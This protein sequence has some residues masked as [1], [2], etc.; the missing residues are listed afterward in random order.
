MSRF[1]ERNYLYRRPDL[2]DALAAADRS[3][4]EQVSRLAAA[5]AVSHTASLCDFGCGTGRDLGQLDG[6]S[7]RVGVDIQEGMISYG[8]RLRPDLDLK[9]GDLR[10]IRLE[11]KFDVLVCLGNS[12]AYLHHDHEQLNAWETFT[13]HARSETLLIIQTLLEPV[14][15][16][17]VR[18][19][20]VDTAV[21]EADT[22]WEI[23]WENDRRIS[24][25]RRTWHIDE[26]QNDVIER[27]VTTPEEL[28]VF[29]VQHGWTVPELALPAGYF[30]AVLHRT[31]PPDPVKLM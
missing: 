3:K 26:P 20:R 18:T 7:R 27:R 4:V 23:S 25:M 9:V 31:G 12:Y 6:F 16:T 19:G 28:T 24:T 10:T 2:Y 15:P 13:A 8:R 11:E 21:L 17:A 1:T 14:E 29:A 30:I 5:H 22:S